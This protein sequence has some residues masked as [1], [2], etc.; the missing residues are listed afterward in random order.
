MR[1]GRRER[2]SAYLYVAV[3]A[4]L[5]GTVLIA[6][7]P[8]A[9]QSRTSQ[10]WRTQR[11]RMKM[12]FDALVAQVR[13]DTGIS[14]I[15]NG[16]TRTLTLNGVTATATITDASSTIA[17]SVSVT[18]TASINGQSM[19]FTRY[20]ARSKALTPFSYAIYTA[21]DMNQSGK[22]VTGA[23]GADGDVYANGKVALSVAGTIING[24]VSAKDTISLGSDAVVT[25]NR[26]ASSNS[27]SLPSVSSLNYTL[28]A[29]YTSLFSASTSSTSFGADVSGHHQIY[30]YTGDL[31]LQGPISGEGVLF[32]GG[33]AYVTGDVS[34]TSSTDAVALIVQGD[35]TI[36]SGCANLVGIIYVKGQVIVESSDV[37]ISRGM[38][39]ANKISSGPCIRVTRDNIVK[40]DSSEGYKLCLPGYWP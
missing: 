38:L 22:I 11:D 14:P 17:N 12:T 6:V 1:R 13:A 16:S 18:G 15:A 3:G 8:L 4:T 10:S 31:S 29:S 5:M 32:V 34:Y 28:G 26:N 9:T 33:N 19:R 39:V 35:L 30:Y 2:G 36:R 21:T 7:I 27:I 37:N 24:D 40:N 20:V 25:G 23:S